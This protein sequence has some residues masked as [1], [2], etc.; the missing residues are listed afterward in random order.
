MKPLQYLAR[1]T[2]TALLCLVFQSQAIAADTIKIGS[3]LSVTG[4]ASFIGDPEL[5][6]LQLYID[7]INAGGGWKG[8][9]IE[10]V[11]YDAASKS[12][13]AVKFAKRLIKKD[14]VDIIIGGSTSGNTLAVMPLME[15]ARMP[16]ISLA[17]SVKITDPTK[18]WVFKTAH[19]DRMAA[20]R[21][22]Q[23]MQKRGIT[24]IALITGDGG[25]DRSG[26]AQCVALAP[27]YGIGIVLDESYGNGD[28]DMTAQLVKVRNTDA[29]AVLN[30]GF[31][32]APALV[33]RNLSQ[34]GIKL[35]LYHSHGIAS[36][37]FIELAGDAAEGVRFPAAALIVA[38]Q[39]SDNDPQKAVL[40]AYRDKFE[41][42][43]KKVSTFGGHAYDALF[44]ALEAMDRA[45]STDRTKVREEIEK[46]QNFSGTGGVF[47]YGPDDHLGLG[48]EAFH[49]V[50]IKNGA[51]VLDK[52]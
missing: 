1:F 11:H 32:R 42:L 52:G 47:N 19:T 7:E 18:K 36:K 28:T 2:L 41:K 14:R 12:K 13:L 3:F 23:D 16:F 50:E 35:P 40:L 43:G 17:A 31:A 38:E 4:G 29:Q 6:T 45:G 33:T 8:K 5:R 34:L 49:M 20:E 25:F 37:T 21:L 10:F 26:H 39:L 27:K 51:W 9:K 30:F 46:T 48:V 22:F 44:I 24:K 15:K